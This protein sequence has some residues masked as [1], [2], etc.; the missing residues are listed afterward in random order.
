[1]TLEELYRVHASEVRRFALYLTGDATEAD[2]ITSETFVR[3]WVSEAPVRA[4]SI[5]AYLFAIARNLHRAAHRRAAA[6]A[7]ALA[8]LPRPEPDLEA[9]L[10]G[11][12]ELR[13]VL[14]RLQALPDTDR[15]ALL[16]R[17]FHNMPYAEIAASLGISVGAAKVKVHRSRAALRAQRR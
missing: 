14:A 4:R 1:M 6:G 7:A 3:A 5:R 10:A 12:S 16:M 9:E 17:A 15:A 11:A 2:D 8:H 13:A